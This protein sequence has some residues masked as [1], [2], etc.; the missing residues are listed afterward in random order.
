MRVTVSYL[1]TCYSD[2]PRLQ[3][4]PRVSRG[5]GRQT[6]IADNCTDVWMD[7][8]MM[9]LLL[10]LFVGYYSVILVSRIEVIS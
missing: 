5:V 10:L 3:R 8:W 7:E 1:P 6:E 2:E 4:A 9:T